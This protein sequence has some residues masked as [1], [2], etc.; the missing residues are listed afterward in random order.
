MNSE[1]R[2]SVATLVVGLSIVAGVCQ[3]ASRAQASADAGTLR[4]RVEPA[5]VVYVDGQWIGNTS[6]PQE[7]RLSPG[8]HRVR[9]V[10]PGYED[11]RRTVDIRA[12]ESTALTIALASSAVPRGKGPARRPL[13]TSATDPDLRSALSF[14]D[15]GDLAA[16]GS[17]LEAVLRDLAGVPRAV[18]DRTV[19]AVYYGATLVELGRSTDA[20]RVFA[21][22]RQLDRR[23][24]PSGT[25]FAAS[26]V[27]QW[28]ASAN[29][30]FDDVPAMTANGLV[31]PAGPGNPGASP[32]PVAPPAAAAADPEPA[33]AAP[34]GAA[35][36]SPAGGGTA[37]PADSAAGSEFVTA[38]A[39]TTSIAM[40][41]ATDA[42]PCAGVVQFESDTRV[43]SWL[44][45]ASC[46]TAFRA[47]FA[48]V[49][50]PA[51]APRGGVLLQ[52]RSDRPSMRLMPAPD[53]DLVQA[54]VAPMTLAELPASTRVNMRRAHRAM[55]LALGRTVSDSIFGLQVDVPL[56]ELFANPAD[57]EGSAVRVSGPLSFRSDRGPFLLGAEPQIL[58]LMPGGS[59]AALLQSSA[60]Q[61]RGKEIVVSGTFSRPPPAPGDRSPATHILTASSVEPVAARENAGEG[62]PATIE[63]VTAAPPPP[64][65][66]MRVVGQF[67]GLNAF[68]DLPIAGR[69]T[70][71]WVIKDGA[72][73]MWVIGR[74]A[75][76]QGFA[77]DSSSRQDQQAWVAVV[78]TVEDVRGTVYLKA[79]KVELAPA[80]EAGR[81]TQ[82]RLRQHAS[83]TPADIGFTAPVL[84]V[85]EASPEQ[86]FVIRFTKPM[87][88]ATFAGRVVMRYAGTT[89]AFQHVSVTYYPDRTFSIM[90][91]PGV[92]LQRGQ[93][94][95]LVFM[96]GI[97]DADGVPLVAPGAA[98]RV[99]TWKVEAQ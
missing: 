72:F 86:Q 58:R 14:Y 84:G 88:E 96:P 33:A 42:G 13:A 39:G 16:A 85:E 87:D 73:A 74:P 81:V 15:E 66:L 61:W 3:A 92:V 41:L 4:V 53:A 20:H 83:T 52:F 91:D 59:T 24:Q 95:E 60:A 89:A 48:E 50:N 5:A 79:E 78:G 28:Q 11:V 64:R 17:V 69:R 93:T 70:G 8:G 30:V 32:P 51:A 77:L 37:V 21:L 71:A 6:D 1:R 57:Y 26:V 80:P 67:R 63:E 94:V 98:P 82:V 65:S 23:L 10:H 55:T 56:A 99:L 27:A 54:D 45:A 34:S 68:G 7:V 29:V 35:E 76:G 97:E 46:S 2:L 62:T 43:V 25:E 40:A 12:R 19:A 90:V 47:P 36:P 22:A 75:S 31:V 9:I 49:R 38:D 44:P 18:R